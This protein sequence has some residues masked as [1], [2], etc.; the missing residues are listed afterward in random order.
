[1]LCNVLVCLAVW[2]AMAGHSVVDKIVA[3]VLPISAFVAAG[4]EHCIANMYFIALGLFLA[5][6]VT[7]PATVNVA[8]L[9]WA[10]LASNL[11]PVA[12][13]N[14]VGGSGMVALVYY[15]VYRRPALIEPRT[16]AE[17]T[18]ATDSPAETDQT[19]D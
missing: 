13:G 19:V 5:E 1:M 8:S 6:G 16:G 18:R 12:L 3:I 15:M 14:I 17:R 11:V 2:L 7:L 4:F 10:G 9:G